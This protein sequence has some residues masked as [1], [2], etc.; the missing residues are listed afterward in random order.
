MGETA[1]RF[2]RWYKDKIDLYRQK[3]YSHE[4]LDKNARLLQH[5]GWLNVPF[6]P[7]IR[8]FLRIIERPGSILDLGCGNGLLLKTLRAQCRYDLVPFGADFLEESIA[9]A[10]DEIL[11]AFR[12]NFVQSNI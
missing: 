12:N 11:P 1:D 5:N 6:H 3:Y 7:A 4:P 9:E 10:R 8:L 2:T